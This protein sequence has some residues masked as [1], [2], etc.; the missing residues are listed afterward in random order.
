MRI[1]P[2]WFLLSLLL[3]LTPSHAVE[4]PPLV[5]ATL[6]VFG[7]IETPRMIRDMCVAHSP[8]MANEVSANYA[9]WK[10][11]HGPIIESANSLLETHREQL[12]PML[13]ST[14]EGKIA[15]LDGVATFLEREMQRVAETKGNAY[16]SQVCSTYPQFLESFDLGYEERLQSQIEVLRSLT[17]EQA[18]RG[19]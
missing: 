3:P 11:R 12:S 15:D 4:L 14:T 17:A 13:N 18:N 5:K 19:N 8:E 7:T 16:M 9:T 1:A 6:S 2:L 10:V